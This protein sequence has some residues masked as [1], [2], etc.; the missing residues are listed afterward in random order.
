MPISAKN[1]RIIVL[2][3]LI[4]MIAVNAKAV[5]GLIH[6]IVKFVNYRL[7]SVNNVLIVRLVVDVN[8]NIL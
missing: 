3:V 8:K 2:I 7:C 5:F 1:A 6:I 4:R